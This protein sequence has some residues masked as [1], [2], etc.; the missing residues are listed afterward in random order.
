MPKETDQRKIA[1]DTEREMFGRPQRYGAAESDEDPLVPSPD[2]KPEGAQ[3]QPSIESLQAE[4]RELK[5]RLERI[6]KQLKIVP[7][8]ETAGGPHDVEAGDKEA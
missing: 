3:A 1:I 2:P 6:E 4:N 8:P 5:A 7:G